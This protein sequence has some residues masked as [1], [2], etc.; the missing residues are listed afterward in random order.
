MDVRENDRNCRFIA[1]EDDISV[2]ATI[3]SGWLDCQHFLI[4]TLFGHIC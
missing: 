1:D 3:I 2:D 4:Q